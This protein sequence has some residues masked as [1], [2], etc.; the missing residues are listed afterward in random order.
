M[1][2]TINLT[3]FYHL[4]SKELKVNT[5]IISPVAL[6]GCETCSLALTEE[7]RLRVFDNEVLTKIFV[8][9]RDEITSEWRKLLNDE[10]YALNYSPNI[11]RTFKS[12]RLR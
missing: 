11:I 7:H 8:A 9:K 1:H 6:H 3:K 12:R 10:V 5:S 4:L 2:L